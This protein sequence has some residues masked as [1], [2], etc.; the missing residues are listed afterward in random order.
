MYCHQEFVVK[1]YYQ[2]EI[3]CRVQFLFMES[4]RSKYTRG[5][6]LLRQLPLE[7]RSISLRRL[8]LKFMQEACHPE[9]ME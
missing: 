8:G 3:L 9:V 2:V 4:I 1:H 7:V 6:L 5:R